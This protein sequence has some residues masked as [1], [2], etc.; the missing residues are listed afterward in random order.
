MLNGKSVCVV[1]PAYNA[2][3]TLERTFR[4]IPSEIA[5][6][7]I[8]VDDGSSDRTVQVAEALGIRHVV[9]P[10][11][12]GYGA[13]QKTCYA[14]ALE[15]GA[16]IVVMLHPDYQYSPRLIPAMVSMIAFGTYDAVIASRILGD[17]AMQGGMPAYKYLSNRALTLFQNILCG[18]KFSEYHTGYRAYS[19][20]V[21]EAIRFQDDA[22]GFVFDNQFFMQMI[23]ARFRI[24]EISCPTLYFPEASSIGFRSS[25][26]YGLGCMREATRCFLHRRNIVRSPLLSPKERPG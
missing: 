25:V 24:G 11:N 21:L 26:R 19:R 10:A 3:A 4:E 1:M 5:D 6:L 14:N 20:E 9:H 8:L 13:N 23:A 2:E 12:R 7:V 16:D 22:D 15:C 18:R 17:G